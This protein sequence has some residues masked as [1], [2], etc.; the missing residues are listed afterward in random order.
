MQQL[1][2]TKFVKL[3]YRGARYTFK[4]PQSQPSRS[5]ASNSD[6]TLLGVQIPRGFKCL[7]YRGHAYLI[8]CY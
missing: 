3:S 1:Q 6:R 5:T 7:L 2:H 4:Q 8:P